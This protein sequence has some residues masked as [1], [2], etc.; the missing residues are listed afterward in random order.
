MRFDYSNAAVDE[1]LDKLAALLQS[2]PEQQVAPEV[3][4]DFLDSLGLQSK[5]SLLVSEIH[6]TFLRKVRLL[7][8]F[9]C[10]YNGVSYKSKLDKPL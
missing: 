4:A 8:F 9:E 10:S 1:A 5:V 2:L 7:D 6:C 3:A